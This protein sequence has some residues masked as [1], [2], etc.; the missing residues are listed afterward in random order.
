LLAARLGT[1]TSGEY[2]PVA[3]A[4]IP[5]FLLIIQM[6]IGFFATAGAVGADFCS[7]NRDANDVKWGGIVGIWLPIVFAGGLAIIAVAG[8]RGADPGLTSLKF[9]DALP[10]LNTTLG[11]IMLI[12][13]AIGSIA[14]ACF[15]SFIIGNSLSTMLGSEK[16]RLPITLGGATI[17]IVLAALGL[18]GQLEA[19]FGLIG[20]SFGPVIGAMIADYLLSGRKWAG[21]RAGISIPGYA[22]WVVGFVVGIQNNAL[23]GGVLPNWEIT[24]V[25]SLVVGFV[26][27]LVL[28]KLGL[29]PR[30]VDLPHLRLPEGEA[31]GEAAAAE[32]GA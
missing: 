26:V 31:G 29:E 21:P 6:V 17:G 12:L 32:S 13:F 11:K 14:P 1:D 16:T 24:S 23:I 15:C 18:A 9:S 10:V 25:Y 19:F 8:A 7:N 27:Y 2:P 28:A 20:A 4:A 3:S 5:G 22:A 30:K